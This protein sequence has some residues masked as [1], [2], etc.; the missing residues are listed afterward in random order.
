MPIKGAEILLESLKREGVEVVFGYPGGANIP[1]YDALYNSPIRHILVRHEQGAAFAAEGYARVS[2][3]PGVAIATSG[4][5]ATNLVTGIADAKLDGIPL[6]CITGQ[7]R[8]GVI[9]TDAFQETDVVG[10]T[11]PITKWNCMVTRTEDIPRLVAQAFYVA[12]SGRPGPVLIDVP[13]DMIRN[14]LDSIEY[15]ETVSLPGYT[16]E[17]ETEQHFDALLAQLQSCSH[18]VVIVGGGIKWAG[19]IQQVRDLLDRLQ[20]PT[21]STVHGLGTVPEDR[22]YFLGMVGMHGTRQSNIAVSHSDLLIVLGARLDDRVTGDASR[23]ARHAKIAHFEIDT[24]QLSRVRPCDIPIVGDLKATVD[25]FQAMLP[26]PLPNWADWVEETHATPNPVEKPAVGT[27]RPS[28]TK[29]LE[30]LF[31]LMDPDGIIA[32]D[33]GQHQMWAAQRA[34]GISG[35]RQHITSGGLG[36]MGF[37]LPASIGAQLAYPHR[38]V[39]CVSGDG[40]FQMNIQELATVQRYSLPLKI[41]IID[42]KYLGMV[43]QWQQLFWD[44]R[45]S[46]VDLYDNPDFNKIAEAYG[47]PGILMDRA[48][49]M[50]AQIKEFLAMPGAAQLVVACPAE[51]N[52]YPMV[53]AG[54][55][56]TDMVWE[57]KKS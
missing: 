49:D 7:V 3:Q 46:E 47:I 41:V 23:F 28:P 54:A 39:V 24:A 12:R 33:V 34:G 55:A 17:K 26:D 31:K 4:P 53:P 36:A 25:Q 30:M 27:G 6:V 44:R 32:T 37:A 15:P 9:G 48:E 16:P 42:N 10:L 40:G 20:V 5:G 19:A 22:K 21:V 56:L 38:Q 43:R 45:Y 8:S 35:P 1:L 57:E 50:E 2:G 29:M 52:V 14:Q 18:P 51:A 11:I 13:V